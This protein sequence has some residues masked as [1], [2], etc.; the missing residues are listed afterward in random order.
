[1][2]RLATLTALVGT[3]LLAAC[4]GGGDATP[5]RISAN[6]AVGEPAPGALAKDDFVKMARS[7]T[8]CSERANRLYVIDGKQMFWEVA[9]NCGDLSYRNT[10]YGLTPQDKQC[11]QEDSIAGPQLKCSDATQRALFETI[12]NNLDKPDLGLGGAHKVELLAFL[13]KDGPVAFE[14]LAFESYSGLQNAETVVI[15]D[16][17]ALQKLWTATYQNRFPAPDMPKVDFARKMVLAVATGMMPNSCYGLA[18]DQVA[19]NGETLV[20]NYRATTPPDSA[21]CLQ[22]I[23]SPVV[24][25]VVDRVDAKVIFIRS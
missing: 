2:H 14:N 22:A 16:Q 12:V 8:L 17:D 1:M 11:T 18:L 3:L 9:G 25:I 15:R 21:I 19:V 7:E 10:L 20:V 24:M 4:G 5:N 23:V 6:I 13:P